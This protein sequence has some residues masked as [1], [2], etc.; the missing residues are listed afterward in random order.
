MNGVLF[1][2]VSLVSYRFDSVFALARIDVLEDA[3]NVG[4]AEEFV[5][6]LKPFGLVR[7]K[8]G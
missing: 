7:W 5:H 8:V 3:E 6:V 4:D 1:P 2:R